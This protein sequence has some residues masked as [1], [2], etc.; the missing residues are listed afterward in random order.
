MSFMACLTWRL[1]IFC[2]HFPPQRGQHR[3]PMSWE[4]RTRALWMRVFAVFVVAMPMTV[5]QGGANVNPI[6]ASPGRTLQPVVFEPLPNRSRQKRWIPFQGRHAPRRSMQAVPDVAFGSDETTWYDFTFRGEETVETELELVRGNLTLEADVLQSETVDVLT[7]L[8]GTFIRVCTCDPNDE[9]C[10]ATSRPRLETMVLQDMDSFGKTRIGLFIDWWLL[11]PKGGST[12][13]ADAMAIAG[14]GL[15][16]PPFTLG[17]ESGFRKMLQEEL[18]TNAKTFSISIETWYVEVSMPTCVTESVI[19][20][21]DHPSLPPHLLQPNRICGD[22]S[23]GG[24]GAGAVLSSGSKTEWHSP[25][26]LCEFAVS[27]CLCAS[28]GGCVWSVS[29]SGRKKCYP[30]PLDPSVS[31]DDCAWQAKCPPVAQD[32]C[33]ASLVPCTCVLVRIPVEDWLEVPYP[34]CYWNVKEKQCLARSVPPLRDEFTR[35]TYCVHQPQDY[36]TGLGELGCDAPIILKI[37]PRPG[38]M[39]PM[40]STSDHINITF[41]RPVMWQMLGDV[42]RQN[43]GAISFICRQPPPSLPK[44][45]PVPAS[46]CYWQTSAGVNYTPGSLN[47]GD[48]LTINVTGTVNA[49]PTQCMLFVSDECIVNAAEL[50]APGVSN[51]PSGYSFGL[52][53]TK[54]PDLRD[55]LPRNGIRNLPINTE[56]SFSFNEEIVLGPTPFVQVLSLGLSLIP[57][58]DSSEEG[59]GFANVSTLGA[60][61]IVANFK[62]TKRNTAFNEKTMVLKL[63]GYLVH[64][65]LYTIGL[66]PGATMDMSENPF[67]GMDVGEYVFRTGPATF[68]SK[69]DA[70]EEGL[71]LVLIVLGAAVLSV[72]WCAILI[73]CAMCLSMRTKMLA[74]ETAVR[75][76]ELGASGSPTW[77]KDWNGSF[78]Q[79]HTSSE[80]DVDMMT[81]QRSFMSSNVS[82]PTVP[83]SPISP[84]QARSP[85]AGGGL[86]SGMNAVS[87]TRSAKAWRIDMDDDPQPECVVPPSAWSPASTVQ[88]GWI[89]RPSPAAS[90]AAARTNMHRLNGHISHEDP[91]ETQTIR[92]DNSSTVKLALPCEDPRRLSRPN[93]VAWTDSSQL[94]KVTSQGRQEK[95]Q[96]MNGSVQGG[97]G[98]VGG[99]QENLSD[100]TLKLRSPRPAN[101]P[102][103]LALNVPS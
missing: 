99:N 73:C 5:G 93:A 11:T 32:F 85:R 88:G 49:F 54:G 74:V 86:G 45:M 100:A 19:I 17:P 47:T 95:M 39:L 69:P 61:K 79:S 56:V 2:M 24:S 4:V 31:C 91:I 84:L 23:D 28:L 44:V 76:K 43:Y 1:G 7:T 50:P 52:L 16:E 72:I 97:N 27:P 26:T 63:S 59:G 42:R 92:F 30:S 40:E 25:S 94:S 80:A 38:Q 67:V 36:P 13:C 41:D 14:Y 48:V 20:P 102:V 8:E 53:D 35:C 33:S 29:E 70:E 10:D 101:Q 82:S 87:K 15:P 18:K 37:M 6:F 98:D 57:G 46:R 81:T 77:N 55:I 78:F 62:L 71:P 65:T 58:E 64:D 51:G 96:L 9:F 103:M 21:A 89:R 60:D 75:E 66:S 90:P 12:A 22:F 3:S 68:V 34:H 83:S